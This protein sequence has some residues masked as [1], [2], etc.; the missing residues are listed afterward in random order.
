LQQLQSYLKP[1]THNVLVSV[2]QNAAFLSD[3][4]RK[5]KKRGDS[6]TLVI[7]TG[8]VFDIPTLENRYLNNLNF[9][10]VKTEFLNTADSSTQGFIQKFRMKTDTE[11]SRFAYAGYD[12]GLY[13]TQLLADYGTIPEVTNWP[14]WRGLNKGFNFEQLESEGP[15]NTFYVKARIVDYQMHIR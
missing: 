14:A 6:I 3:F 4:I 7:A 12:V 13:F 2:D 1:D 15:R 8:R 5:Q 11:P 10:G 9:V